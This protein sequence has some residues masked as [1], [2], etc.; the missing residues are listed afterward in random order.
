MQANLHKMMFADGTTVQN[1]DFSVTADAV[2]H[3]WFRDHAKHLCYL[4]AKTVY[5]HG[6][7]AW[8]SDVQVLLALQNAKV[9][10]LLQKEDFL[11]A[12]RRDEDWKTW[13]SEVY[14]DLTPPESDVDAVRCVGMVRDRERTRGIM[15]NKFMVF[16]DSKRTPYAV[17]TGSYNPSYFSNNSL[18]NSLVIYSQ[19][20][21]EAYLQ[22]FQLINKLSEPLDWTY[23]FAAP[24]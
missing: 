23:D 2:V 11:R 8:L 18:E 7:V 16:S 21:A 19:K 9:Q 20:I 22:E 15:H 5:V 6:C 24:D 12:D 13:L 14:A 10:L 17:W 1:T 4:I 3:V